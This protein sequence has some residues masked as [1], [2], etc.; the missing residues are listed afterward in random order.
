ML[1]V[2]EEEDLWSQRADNAEINLLLWRHRGNGQTRTDLF[3]TQ[4]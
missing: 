1:L 2:L 3:G 4:A